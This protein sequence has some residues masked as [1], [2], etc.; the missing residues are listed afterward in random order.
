VARF[1]VGDVRLE[2][3]APPGKEFDPV[4]LPVLVAEEAP[5]LGNV[6]ELVGVRLDGTTV[7]PG[8][9]LSVT[10]YWRALAPIDASY[11][12]FVQAV[13]ERGAKAGQVDRLP[14]N[15]GCPTTAW[16]PGDLVGEWYDLS[17]GIDTPPGRYQLIAGMYDLATGQ[18]LSV[19][20]AQGQVTNDH[21]LLG[22]AEV[23]P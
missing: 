13:D 9:T 16:H 23:L 14:C 17:I 8:E 11:T 20:D 18:R 4:R 10:L 19:L 5:N 15:G 1:Q 7:P 3:S 21:V 22:T 2:Y 6:V 12:V